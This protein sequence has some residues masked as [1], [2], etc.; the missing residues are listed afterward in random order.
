MYETINFVLTHVTIIIFVRRNTIPESCVFFFFFCNSPSSRI[1]YDTKTA[2]TVDDQFFID[3]SFTD[4][5][6]NK[7]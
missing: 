6:H 4:V 5:E 7:Y 1:H 3:D 2:L